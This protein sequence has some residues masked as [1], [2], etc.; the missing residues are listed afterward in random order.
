MRVQLVTAPH[1]EPPVEAV[2]S[3]ALSKRAQKLQERLPFGA[4]QGVE[5]VP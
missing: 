4:R 5:S 2:R 1:N 3:D